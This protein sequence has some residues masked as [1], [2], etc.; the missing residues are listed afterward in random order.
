MN[1]RKTILTW[2][3]SVFLIFSVAAGAYAYSSILAFGD[4]LSDN[5]AATDGHGYGTWTNG[6]V[7]L[8]YLANDLGVGSLNDYAY[9]GATTGSTYPNVNWQIGDYLSD[10][11]NQISSGS[12][13]TLWAGGNDFLN[14]FTSGGDVNTTI[15]NA[16]VNMQSALTSLVD[17]GATDILLLT[18]P[19]LGMTPRLNWNATL[20]AQGTAISVAYNTALL[21]LLGQFSA[22]QGLDIYTL[23][24]F[25]IMQGLKTDAGE[26]DNI[27][28]ALS[29]GYGNIIG[30][31]N[32]TY[33]FWDSIHPTTQGHEMIAQYA[34]QTVSSVPEPASMLLVV[35]GLAGL[36]GLRRLKK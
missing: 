13:V 26:F 11:G 21:S 1:F 16:V 36:T 15:L 34:Y 12:L 9:G 25:G 30:D 7:W 32:L 35:L 19:D 4:S 3:L 5:G 28:N 23:D 2:L 18:L 24:V 27:T 14:L 31:P 29:D 22:T 20:S 10:H 6:Q 8:Q 17:H 33:L